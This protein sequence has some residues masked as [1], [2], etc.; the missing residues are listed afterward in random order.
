VYCHGWAVQGVQRDRI[1]PPWAY[2]VG[3][4]E[5]GRP[6]LVV[7]WLPLPRAV[8]LLN[9]AASHVL[10]ADAP[11]PGER[12]PLIGGPVIEIVEVA[13]AN[14]HLMTAVELYGP[15]IGVAA[16]LAR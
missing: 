2:T 7:T 13:V 11:Q 1:R 16:Y 14:A 5:A 15:A 10:H 3:L 8:D 9:D 6:E 4:T 12:L